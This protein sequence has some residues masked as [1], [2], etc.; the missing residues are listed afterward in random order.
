[1]SG[2]GEG[3]AEPPR[4]AWLVAMLA[5]Q[6]MSPVQANMGRAG[7]LITQAR[8]HV[9]SGRTLAPTDPTLALAACHDAIRKAI[10]AHAGARGYRIENRP[11][12]HKVVLDYARNELA[13]V[14]AA[15]DLTEADR[16]RVRR[17]SAEYGEILAR[18]VTP[19]EI[20]RYAEIAD[21]IVKG[22][23]RA[24]AGLPPARC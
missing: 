22:V 24:V 3:S 23:A 12:H 18:S 1:M 10:D 11:G 16:L 13:G 7:D 5:E 4:S 14:I 21:R 17:H 2:G 15:E 19:P 8:A 9:A 6:R 20:A